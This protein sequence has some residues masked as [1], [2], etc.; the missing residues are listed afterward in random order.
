MSDIDVYIDY[1]KIVSSKEKQIK[2]NISHIA[3]KL[4]KLGISDILIADKDIK[5]ITEEIEAL[6]EI[7][8]DLNKRLAVSNHI[9]ES[10]DDVDNLRDN[11]NSTSRKLSKMKDTITKYKPDKISS[12]YYK[13]EIDK[14]VNKI[15][16]LNA[17]IVSTNEIINNELT[18]IN[19]LHDQY[20]AALNQYEKELSTDKTIK[21]MEDNLSNIR[22]A[23]RESEDLL[24][25]YVPK[26]SYDEFNDFTN[27][28]KNLTVKL[29]TTYEFGTKAINKV[30]KLMDDGIDVDHYISSH[31]IDIDDNTSDT[32]SL[33]LSKLYSEFSFNNSTVSNCSCDCEAKLVY[34]AIKNIC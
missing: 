27:F 4:S 24:G 12:Q 34:N 5:N 25:D 31:L 7:N 14:C 23:L 9:I 28:I 20:Q 33:F 1:F 26:F 19:I 15:T 32:T 11:L 8:I 13:D 29:S 2:D 17:N 18:N 22:K 21:Q 6:N 3:N 16:E 10:I 30:L